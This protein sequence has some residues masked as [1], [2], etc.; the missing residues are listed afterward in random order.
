MQAL[1]EG[2][3]LQPRTTEGQQRGKEPQP[4]GRFLKEAKHKLLAKVAAACN[5]V[6]DTPKEEEVR[7]A[8]RS[9]QSRELLPRL[10]TAGTCTYCVIS[11]TYLDHSC[12]HGCRT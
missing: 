5:P 8:V 6:D 9:L 2:G 10:R 4:R 1:L 12:M 7:F 11:A 3:W